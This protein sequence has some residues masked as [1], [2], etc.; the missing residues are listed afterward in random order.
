MGGSSSQFNSS[1][2]AIEALNGADLTG[3]VALITGGN[4]GIGR[5]I[6]KALALA[7][8]TV[9]LAVRSTERG[10]TAKT[11]IL[12]EL[13]RK[14]DDT[15]IHVL[16]MDCGDLES[17]R[18]FPQQFDDLGLPLHYLICN[19][20]VFPSERK[21]TKQGYEFN[22]GINHLAHYYLV[23][24]M[25][26][27]L[28]ES[29]PS[30]VITISS[31]GR[32]GVVNGPY[33][34]QW[35]DNRYGMGD[36]VV[37][38]T[39][40]EYSAINAYGQSKLFNEL[41]AREICQRYGSVGV[42]GVSTRPGMTI[43]SMTDNAPFVLWVIVTLVGWMIAKTAEQGAGTM[44]RCIVMPDDEIQPGGFYSDCQ[45]AESKLLTTGPP[46]ESYEYKLWE[47]SARLLAKDGFLITRE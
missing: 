38:P 21:V 10:E 24:L 14:E 16:S 18:A 17:I 39:E 45:I 31:Q 7:H 42:I 37:G 11:E 32:N 34:D 23:N 25:M 1:T 12:T 35:I 29:A 20:G 19:A 15:S 43:T 4:S 2:T 22:F 44:V 9:V 30:R 47:L 8:A 26:G 5:E 46:E 41:M 33:G 13:E 3:R 28:K 6:V 40:E 27:K 36:D